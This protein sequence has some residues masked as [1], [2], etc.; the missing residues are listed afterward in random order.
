[1]AVRVS[2][3]RNGHYA[4]LQCGEKTYDASSRRAKAEE[5]QA[6]ITSVAKLRVSEPGL[7]QVS[8]GL[9]LTE[10]PCRRSRVGNRFQLSVT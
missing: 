10:E 1:M 5:T 7:L 8:V 2:F 4:K 3:S 9:K 6:K